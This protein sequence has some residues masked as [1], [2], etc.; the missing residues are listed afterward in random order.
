MFSLRN[1]KQTVCLN[2]NRQSKIDST[3]T[4]NHCPTI[5]CTREHVIKYL[6]RRQPAN[7]LCHVPGDP[8]RWAETNEKTH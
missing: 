6:L 1:K 5:G 3:I 7:T 8:R 2:K 4:E